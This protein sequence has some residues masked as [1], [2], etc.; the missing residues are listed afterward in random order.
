[1]EQSCP[2]VI[3]FGRI[4][5]EYIER[6]AITEQI[7]G[8]FQADV[9]QEDCFVLTGLRGSG[10]TVLFSRIL[11]IVRQDKD[12]I[13]INLN[14]TMDLLQ[15]LVAKL[16]DTSGFMN[17]FIT[18]NLNLSKFGIGI[19]IDTLPPA[20]SLESSLEKILKEMKRKG[21]KL[22]VGIDEVAPTDSMKTFAHTFQSMIQQGLPIYL[23]MDG[24]YQNVSDLSNDNKST[25]LK[26]AKKVPVER[27]NFTSM[28]DNYKSILKID[29][30][31]AEEM[32]AITRGYAVAYQALGRY[33]WFEKDHKLTNHV[34]SQFDD[35]LKEYVYE[36]IW[37][38]LTENER[39]YL[40]FLTKKP[41]MDVSELLELAGK[42]K[43]DFSRYRASLIAKGIIKDERGKVI[44]MLPRF[45]NFLDLK[46][47]YD[48]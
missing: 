3:N 33:A 32:A 25:F 27:L 28:R 20:A 4:P 14:I 47:K 46:V 29:D 1:M 6:T 39:Y 48:W 26:R 15:E 12:F 38:E 41:S 7:V 44:L 37:T 16:Y 11:N 2:Y 23:L 40:S 21:K 8:A 42:K 5:T 30:K 19:N 43:T 34:F 45:E 13:V 18:T 24:L 9:P 17:K 36:Q 35:V 31:Q 10:K 22:L